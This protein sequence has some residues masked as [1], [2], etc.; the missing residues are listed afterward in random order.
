[1][2]VVG[3][4]APAWAPDGGLIAFTSFRNGR[5]DIYVM[6]PD[7]KAQRRLT[8]SAAHDDLPAWSPDSKRIAFTSD[9]SGNLEIW[10]M[11]ADG[12]DQKQLTFT[13]WRN[14]SPTWSPDG[15]RIAFRSDRD[16][17]AEI[18]SM[19]ADG[20]DVQRLTFSATSDNSPHWGPDG[21]ILFV[22]NRGSGS[23]NVLWVMNGDGSDQH[24]FTPT[25]F[26]WNELRP[27]WSPDG[28]RVAF[29]ADRDGPVGNTE[30]YV[31]SLDGSELQRLT[32]Y[33]GKDDWPTWS[34]D[35]T[36]IVFARG[37]SQ[38]QNEVYLVAAGGGRA[39]ELTLPRLTAV[40]FATIPARP[41]A[42]RHV[43][44]LYDVIEESG[45]DRV[46]PTV[47]CSARLGKKPLRVRKRSFDAYSGRASCAWFMPVTAT[48]KVLAGTI[49]VGGPSGTISRRFS[50]RVR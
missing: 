3:D 17:D 2:K 27:A 50:V 47:S 13:E 33:P 18:Y 9:R 28:R 44:V 21:R 11:N 34:P 19:S 14:F 7:G 42:G 8:K 41:V 15:R 10:V 48:G 22:S 37:P 26:Y 35:G 38:F 49:A 46:S 20:S 30:L 40:N 16:G 4:D 36:E 29:Q 6:R 12:S 43:T 45:A 32:V 5:G 31:M 1:V 23:K 25:T 39:R 24:R